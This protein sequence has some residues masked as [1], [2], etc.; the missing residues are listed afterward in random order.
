MSTTPNET[1]IRNLP[2]LDLPPIVDPPLAKPAPLTEVVEQAPVT[3]PAKP[4]Q[5][6]PDRSIRENPLVTLLAW[7]ARFVVGVWMI[8]NWFPLSFIT[9][10]AAF[11]WLQ[12]RMQALALRGWWRHSPRRFEGTFQKFC[13]SLGHDA[14]VERPCWFLRER[15]VQTL[16]RARPGGPVRRFIASFFDAVTLPIHSLLVNFRVGIAGLA[17]T[18]M[19]TGWPCSIM[20]FSW[21]FGWLNSFHKGYEDAFLGL[22]F[23]LF[24]S[25]LLILTLVYVPMAQAHQA[26]TGEIAAFFQFRVV[27][28]LILTRLTAYTLLIAGLALTSLVFEIPRLFAASQD[29]AANTAATPQEAYWILSRWWFNWSIFF[30]AALLILRTL[31]A[32]IYRSAMLKAIHSG[33]ILPSD[34]PPRLALWFEKLEIMPQAQLPQHPLATMLKATLSLKWRAFLFGAIFLIL[35]LFVLRFYVGYFLVF[36]EYRG[37]LN[38]PVFQ[39]PTID[40]TPWHLVFG[41]EE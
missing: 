11:G 31:A 35:L 14:P 29:F 32:I 19:V 15:I 8:A 16:G 37:I 30:F 38:H 10:I 34:L 5:P 6:A 2:P 4:V 41:Q 24:G 23:G 33:A 28:R 25:F 13:D 40:W 36:N 12:R 1:G 27:L 18:Y 26:A 17:S 39:V 20:L 3:P 21:Y 9:A 7:T 22:G